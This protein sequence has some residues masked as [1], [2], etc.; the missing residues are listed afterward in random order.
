MTMAKSRHMVWSDF[1]LKYYASVCI[2]TVHK[3]CTKVYIP[4]PYVLC[5]ATIID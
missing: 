2:Y 4:Q 1:T 5:K 3:P